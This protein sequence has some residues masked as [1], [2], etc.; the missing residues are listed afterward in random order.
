MQ[1][2]NHSHY[3]MLL[4]NNPKAAKEYIAQFQ[5]VE[6]VTAKIDREKMTK[7]LKAMGIRVFP[8][9][10]DE[11]VKKMYEEAKQSLVTN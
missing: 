5:T 6:Q 11:T 4:G 3:A 1:Q 8:N 10:K 7:E 2:F 9:Y